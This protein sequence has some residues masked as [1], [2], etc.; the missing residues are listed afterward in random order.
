MKWNWY[1]L[2]LRQQQVALLVVEGKLNTFGM[3]RELGVSR[4][5]FFL[6]LRNA[7]K[8]LDIRYGRVQ[9]AFEV[10]RHWKEMMDK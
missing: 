3:C 5:M 1:K 8:T 10:G 7:L 4:S 9:L 2:T 6:H